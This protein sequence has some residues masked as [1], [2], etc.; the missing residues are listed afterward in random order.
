MG[1]RSLANNSSVIYASEYLRDELNTTYSTFDGSC[2]NNCAMRIQ[3]F[4]NRS[5]RSIHLIAYFYLDDSILNTTMLCIEK[6]IYTEP[7][8][9]NIT[10]VE[11]TSTKAATVSLSCLNDDPAYV[12]SER[13]RIE[14]QRVDKLK[15]IEEVKKAKIKAL[16]KKF[17]ISDYGRIG[18]TSIAILFIV[19]LYAFVVLLD[20]SN[21]NLLT[22][23]KS[24]PG[25][26][27]AV[28]KTKNIDKSEME[29]EKIDV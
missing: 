2:N 25:T 4:P 21:W 17:K 22:M 23:C 7:I 10:S 16:E 14:G 29:P 27:T 5:L 13:Q 1:L 3:L 26:S 24:K 6:P 12:A 11:S 15:S 19:S 9:L 18:F 8:T 20:F 28:G